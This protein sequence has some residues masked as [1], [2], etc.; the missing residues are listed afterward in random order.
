MAPLTTRAKE[1]QDRIHL[2][3]STAVSAETAVIKLS[4]VL[5]AESLDACRCTLDRVLR[6]RPLR[7]VLDV[8]GVEVD[9]STLAE[10][11]LIRR[12][13]QRSGVHL[14]LAGLPH[15]L[16]E[17]IRQAQVQDL[18]DIQSAPAVSVAAELRHPWRVWSAAPAPWGVR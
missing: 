12:Y 8:A 4:G 16:A 2:S 1:Q 3:A 11:G 9:H 18:Y 7:L 14:V 10:L 13:L 17:A 6:L 15:R 5:D